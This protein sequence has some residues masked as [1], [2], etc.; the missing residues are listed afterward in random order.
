M[1]SKK[2]K[3][4]KGLENKNE[5]IFYFKNPRYKILVS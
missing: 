2:P 3:L 5:F 4:Y 1:I